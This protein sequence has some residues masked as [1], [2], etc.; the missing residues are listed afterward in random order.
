ML[1]FNETVERFQ[2]NYWSKFSRLLFLSA[3]K[4]AQEAFGAVRDLRYR[5]FGKK[6]VYF[7]VT[8]GR[9]LFL[10]SNFGRE[11]FLNRLGSKL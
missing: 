3:E 6:F 4:R 10:N 2:I 7:F 11:K 9:H 1:I 8:N 5:L